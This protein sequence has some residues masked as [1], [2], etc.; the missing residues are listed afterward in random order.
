[1]KALSLLVCWYKAVTDGQEDGDPDPNFIV[2]A[3]TPLESPWTS[4]EILQVTSYIVY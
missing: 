1:M 2:P 3:F 4:V